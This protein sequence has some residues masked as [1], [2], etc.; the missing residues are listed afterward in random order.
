MGDRDHDL[1]FGIDYRRGHG[2]IVTISCGRANPAYHIPGVALRRCDL[3]ALRARAQNR[4]TKANFRPEA[5]AWFKALD[6]EVWEGILIAMRLTPWLIYAVLWLY[7]D[8]LARQ[9]GDDDGEVN[10]GLVHGITGAS[11]LPA[12]R[13]LMDWLS[14]HR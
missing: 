9:A 14:P 1:E 12:G 11:A 4:L 5:A 2:L 6:Q 10:D 3:S 7:A 13:A 8:H